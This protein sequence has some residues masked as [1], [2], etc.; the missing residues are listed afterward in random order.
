VLTALVHWFP[1]QEK[2]DNFYR[3]VAASC[4]DVSLLSGYLGS[5][6][7]E[8]WECTCSLVEK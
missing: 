7:C 6:N 3:E 4:L 8:M 1:L 5:W 2:A